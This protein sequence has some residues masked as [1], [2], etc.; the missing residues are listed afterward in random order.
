MVRIPFD[1]RKTHPLPPSSLL[2]QKMDSSSIAVMVLAAGQGKRMHSSLPKVLHSVAGRPLIHHILN[3]V[4]RAL[5][6]AK[7]GVIV[8]HGKEEVMSSIQSEPLFSG[9]EIQFIP[10]TEQKGTGHAA[11]CA[12][13]SS[14]GLEQTRKKRLVLVVPGD[15]PLIPQSLIEGLAEGLGRGSVMRLLTCS[16]PDPTGY[17]RVVRRGKKGAVLR[18]VEEKDA[19]PREKLIQEVAA[20]LYAFD[21][22]FLSVSLKRLTNK[23]AQGEYYLTDLV[24]FASTARKKIEGLL[25]ENPE[26]VRGV[27]DPWELAVAGRMMNDR[28]LKRHGKAGVRFQD[29]QNTWVDDSVVIEAGAQI[30]AGAHL[31]GSTR[32]GKNCKVGANSWIKDSE[33]SA[34]AEIKLGSVIEQSRVFPHA[35][36]GPYAHLRP[37]SQVGE[38]AKIGNFVELKKTTVGSHTSI[39]HLSYAGDAEIGA[40]VNIGCGFVTCNFDGRVIEGSRKHKTIIEDDVFMGSD[41]Q[42]IAPVRVGKGAYV[43]SGSTISQNVEA[44]ALAIARSRQ[45]NKPGYAKR[46]RGH[47]SKEGK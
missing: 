19:N 22:S 21:S 6:K 14:W 33:I 31:V 30:G 28:I 17:G 11:L 8:G 29:L 36:V 40:H 35:K 25:W 43:A 23:N 39:A 15:L 26:D 4:F 3:Q 1:G 7:V 12:M 44:D 2:M 41:C 18:I 34:D 27:N 9:K 13:E 45:V 16:L 20:S 42:T 32:L 46:L 5:P 38:S 37:E 10:Q 24:S 47:S